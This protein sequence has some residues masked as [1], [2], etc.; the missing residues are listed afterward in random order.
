M[1]GFVEY[2]LPLFLLVFL[3]FCC[4][5]APLSHLYLFL[6]VFVCYTVFL[7]K[8]TVAAFPAHDEA[9]KFLCLFVLFS[10]FTDCSSTNIKIFKNF[11]G[12]S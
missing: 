10:P 11:K 1:L 6:E 9:P 8:Q 5:S 7:F 4:I 12:S 2:P 3:I